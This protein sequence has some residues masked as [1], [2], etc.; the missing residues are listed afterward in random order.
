MRLVPGRAVSVTQISIRTIG[1]KS[2]LM[3]LA[4][5]TPRGAFRRPHHPPAKGGQ[6]VLS[7]AIVTNLGHTAIQLR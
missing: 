6:G 1:G 4:P 7:D 5:H 3:R 2:V